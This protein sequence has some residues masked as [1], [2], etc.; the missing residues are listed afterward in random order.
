MRRI[1]LQQ[2]LVITK[3]VFE[4]YFGYAMD[5]GELRIENEK[6]KAKL[7]AGI[8]FLNDVPET[9]VKTD[10]I[11]NILWGLIQKYKAFGYSP[12]RFQEKPVYYEYEPETKTWEVYNRPS[13]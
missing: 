10:E 4:K 6:G 5:K 7:A 11:Y 1:L 9:K 8:Y 13:K 2:H 3:K 12:N